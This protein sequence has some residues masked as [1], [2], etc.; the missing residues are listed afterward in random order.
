MSLFA[1]QIS[2][3]AALIIDT[4]KQKLYTVLKVQGCSAVEQYKLSP[5]MFSLKRKI[6]MADDRSLKGG[7]PPKKKAKKKAAKKKATTKAKKR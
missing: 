1:T 7:E 5:R 3:R 6:T 2:L 4:S